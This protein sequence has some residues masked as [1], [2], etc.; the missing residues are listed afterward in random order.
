MTV[1]DLT[2]YLAANA[3]LIAVVNGRIYPQTLPQ[4]A[5]LPAIVYSQIHGKPGNTMENASGFTD[6]LFQFA[7]MAMSYSDA[8]KT[9]KSLRTAL[10]GFAGTMGAT[11]V[12]G[13]FQEAERDGFDFETLEYR[14]DLDFKFWHLEA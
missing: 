9:A 3:G 1:E 14:T 8:K 11:K 5:T 12:Y 13:A 6:A 7:C 2:A 10:E 4:H